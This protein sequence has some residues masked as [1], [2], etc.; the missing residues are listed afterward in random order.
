MKAVSIEAAIRADSTE[1]VKAVST[2]SIRA[3]STEDVKAISIEAVKANSTKAV[4]AVSADAQF[5]RAMAQLTDMGDLQDRMEIPESWDIPST[6]SRS[7]HVVRNPAGTVVRSLTP[8]DGHCLYRSVSEVMTGG[9]DGWSQLR[10]ATVG[11]LK[12]NWQQMQPSYTFS[13]KKVLNEVKFGAAM[14]MKKSQVKESPAWA[15]DGEQALVAMAELLGVTQEV[16]CSRQGT[17]HEYGAGEEHRWLYFDED[18][19][20]YEAMHQMPEG[21]LF[22]EGAVEAQQD[23][24]EVQ[25][26]AMPWACCK[27]TLVNANQ[28]AT[29][30]ACAAC[31][32]KR[33]G[34]GHS[35]E[36]SEGELISELEDRTGLEQGRILSTC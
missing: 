35:E 2:E 16:R 6:Q 26:H 1:A 9:R 17:V 24:A 28:E 5:G 23:A 27:C 34:D 30:L 3:D 36:S 10:W 22:S 15:W 32:S 13:K 19:E 7:D 8:T 20:H 4:K 11:W 14:H 21:L 33:E 25:R 12:Q 29:F 31:D 18:R